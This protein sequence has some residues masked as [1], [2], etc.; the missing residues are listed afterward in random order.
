MLKLTNNYIGERNGGSGMIKKSRV[1]LGQKITV[2]VL[3]M[4]ILIMVVLSYLVITGVTK[5]TEETTIANMKT[6]VEERSQIIRNYVK[7]AEGTLVAYSKA[8]EIQNVLENQQDAG[9]AAAAQA[10][11]EKFSKDVANLEGLYTG[12]SNSLPPSHPRQ[13][14]ASLLASSIDLA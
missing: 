10:Y 2:C 4:Q 3:V 9:A 6:I 1:T 12:S 5:D 8:G 11:T 7:E 14:Y 13:L